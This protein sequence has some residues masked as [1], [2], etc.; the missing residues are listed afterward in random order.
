MPSINLTNLSSVFSS[1][2]HVHGS[3]SSKALDINRWTPDSVIVDVDEHDREYDSNDCDYH[4]EY[5]ID[6]DDHHGD[7]EYDPEND[8][9]DRQSVCNNFSGM[10]RR[11]GSSRGDLESMD[12][13]ENIR[14][15]HYNIQYGGNS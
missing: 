12:S 15:I 6:D 5:F 9:F 14:N 10:F 1:G 4:N 8:V 13:I 3:S 11:T 7:Y 2:D